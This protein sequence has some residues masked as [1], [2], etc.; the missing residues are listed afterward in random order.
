MELLIVFSL[1]IALGVAW[2]MAVRQ[3]GSEK[4][5]NRSGGSRWVRVEGETHACPDCGIWVDAGVWEDNTCVLPG[6]CPCCGGDMTA[7]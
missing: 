2:G 1:G 7:D 5:P 3:I 4:G 6:A